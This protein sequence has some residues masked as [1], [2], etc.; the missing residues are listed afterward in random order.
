[1]KIYT[2]L[3]NGTLVKSKEPGIYAGWVPGR[4]FGRL[5]CTSG[6]KMHRNNRVFFQTLEDAI[7]EGYRPCKKCRPINVQDFESI[8]YLISYKTIEEFYNR[9]FI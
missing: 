6:M 1:M 4:I 8:S 5:D 9:D 3:K 7:R 2:I